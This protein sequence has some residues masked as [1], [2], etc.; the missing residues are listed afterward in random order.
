ML[1][2]SL[3]YTNQLE[4]LMNVKFGWNEQEAGIY[5][6][7]IGAA[8]VVGMMIGSQLSGTVIKRGRRNALM[9][10]NVMGMIA[11]L[12]TIDRNLYVIIVARLFLGT[13]VGIINGATARFIEENVPGY[14]YE[15]FSPMVSIGYGFGTIISFSLAYLIP[16][17][18]D[19]EGLKADQNWK[20]IYAYVPIGIYSLMMIGLFVYVKEEPIKYLI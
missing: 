15:V 8:V 3:S 20:I 2:Y 11:C 4:P 9:L 10:G 1:G 16:A 6:G 13:S 19:I 12:T 14:L 7:M 5:Q 18:T 17:D